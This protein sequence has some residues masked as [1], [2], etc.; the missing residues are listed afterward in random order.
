MDLTQ[1]IGIIFGGEDQLSPIVAGI[2]RKLTA[3]Q[4]GVDAI[5]QPMARVTDGILA[6]DAAL[7][8]LGIAFLAVAEKEAAK[9]QSAQ[10]DFKKVLDDT[11]PSIDTFTSSVDALS[12][13]YG[14]SAA[15]ILQGAADFKQAGF[16][17]KNVIQLQT[18]A[19]DLMIAG[20][21]QAA[22]SSDYLVRIL[23]GF[24]EPASS[25]RAVID[26]LNEVSNKYATNVKQLAIGMADLSPVAKTMGFSFQETEGLLTPVIEIF[27]SGSEAA[28]AFKTGLL[29]LIDDAK[30]V[31]TALASIGVAQ[32]DVNGNLRSGKDIFMDVARAFKNLD[33]NQKLFVTSQLVGI[34]QSA[35]MVK[36]FD[37]LNKISEV[38]SV[39]MNSNGS[40]AK[41]VAI[42][43]E[44][45][46][47]QANRMIVAF[48][49][50]AR[51]VGNELLG[52]FGGVSKGITSIEVAFKQ[53][54]ESGGLAPLL[55][56]IRPQLDALGR[57]FEEAA[58][59]LPAAFERLDFSGLVRSLERQG[60]AI[61]HV[62]ESIFG[63]IDLSTPEGLAKA[64]QRAIDG[65]A[66]LGNV[67]AGIV[68]QFG[69]IAGFIG[70]AIDRSSQASEE[71]QVFAGKMLGAAK[72][73][74]EFGGAVAA[75][76]VVLEQAGVN[77]HDFG[78]VI[79]GVIGLMKNGADI[80]TDVFTGA[81]A[82]LG[83]GIY[84]F[85]NLI[86]FGAF[87]ETLG[88]L[89]SDMSAILG[90][91]SD[92]ITK[93]G[94]EAGEA[95]DNL[96]RGLD[97]LMGTG[98]KAAL[99]GAKQGL[100]D[101]GTEAKNAS[102]ALNKFEPID[103]GNFDPVA[104][105]MQRMKAAMEEAAAAA[106][107]LNGVPLSNGLRDIDSALEDL[108]ATQKN[109]TYASDQAL[110][111][112]GKYKAV[113]NELG[114]TVLVAVNKEGEKVNK[115]IERQQKEMEKAAQQ[116]ADYQLK[117][118]EIESEERT[119]IIKARFEF[120]QAELEAETKQ[121]EAA[122]ASISEGI[123]STGDVLKSLSGDFLKASS[124]FDKTII[125]DY[126]E[127]E[128]RRRDEEFKLQ[129]ELTEKEIEYM[130]IKNQKLLNGD[131]L[132][133]VEAAGLEPALEMILFEVL[134]KIQIRAE[135]E[136]ADFLLG[137]S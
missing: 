19:L 64:L 84:D 137:I 93:D 131:N 90:R 52:Q 89:S 49:N 115:T 6:L 29:K 73:L 68:E 132:I 124:E 9:F 59:N 37:D 8:G 43:L 38:T 108:T 58:Q 4:V 47:V 135:A 85:L 46:E 78:N 23:K 118:R 75:L 102:D 77:M 104:T 71:A 25:A 35:K 63:E 40:A 133:K 2:D 13:K 28:N 10:L 20:D 99:E 113:L 74:V 72:L 31:A 41:E 126:M 95:L 61:Q 114:E 86:T 81:L 79:F 105:A 67:T 55:D 26:S 117:L 27:G 130:R 70:D 22:E 53:V 32:K 17:T 125:R 12:L 101:I 106:R 122:F 39:A 69:P 111:S 34:D 36:A 45:A 30:P 119:T 14:E 98:P 3:F 110:V 80:I 100:Q 21:L 15:K 121:I 96:A 88:K 128:Q 7:T 16:E 109:Q 65:L 18:D 54:V 97:G 129:K 24:Q 51:A 136:K 5:A 92:N 66:L 76:A 56:A 48:E 83:K 123:N 116:A 103:L 120:N 134:R 33:E 87:K 107:D 91:I 42:R 57:V 11:D 127:K 112:S 44:S 82:I 1:T 62:F 94:M 60:A 50:L